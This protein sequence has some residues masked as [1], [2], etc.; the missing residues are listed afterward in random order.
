MVINDYVHLGGFN[1]N[2]RNPFFSIEIVFTL[3][4][5][6]ELFGLIFVLA[7]SVANSVGKQFELLSLIFLRDGFKEFSHFGTNLEWSLIKDSFTNMMIYGFGAVIIFAV[8]G[9]N[10]SLQKHIKLTTTEE[11]QVQFIRLKKML[12]LMLLAAFMIV[13]FLDLKVLIETGSYLHSFHT[14]YTVLIFS[15]ILIVLIALRFTF[16]YYKI[17]RYSAFVLATILIRVSLSVEPVYD[18]IVG[19]TAS[20]FILAL[21]ITYNYFLK[22]VPENKLK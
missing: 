1:E 17:F 5:I 14:F 15:D 9:L 7:R 19:V 20:L 12:A 4:L 16:N 2:F 22:D 8:I 3:L 6:I 13:G 21:T 18:V 10:K 11:E